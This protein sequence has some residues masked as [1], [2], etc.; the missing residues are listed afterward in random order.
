MRIVRI[1]KVMYACYWLDE[2]YEVFPEFED[3]VFC[4]RRFGSFEEV[5]ECAAAHIFT[6]YVT[7]FTLCP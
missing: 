1:R 2:L 6:Q 4:C 5:R 3:L 7:S